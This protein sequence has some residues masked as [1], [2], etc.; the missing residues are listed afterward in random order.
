M[1]VPHA[2]NVS[3]RPTNP[4]TDLPMPSASAAQQQLADNLL[5]RLIDNGHAVDRAA[6][7]AL[8]DAL[9]EVAVRQHGRTLRACLTELRETADGLDR[10][11]RGLVVE[12]AEGELLYAD[13]LAGAAQLTGSAWTVRGIMLRGD[14][15]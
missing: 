11:A 5:A 15:A 8:R 6:R 12:G 9:V 10:Q 4:D 3:A 2:A 1:S 14:R 7:D 13:K